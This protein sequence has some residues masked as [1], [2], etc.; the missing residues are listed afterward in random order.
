MSEPR[1]LNGLSIGTELTGYT[2]TG[3]LGEGGFA[4]VYRAEDRHLAALAAAQVMM[5]ASSA[6]L[7]ASRAVGQAAPRRRDVGVA[8]WAEAGADSRLQQPVA[9]D[10][11]PSIF[12]GG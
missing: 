5:E 8:T 4:I 12:V 9:L 6:S 1:S 11:V 7:A 2:V 3:V 10:S